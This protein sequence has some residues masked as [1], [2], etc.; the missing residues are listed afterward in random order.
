MTFLCFQVHRMMNTFLFFL[1]SVTMFEAQWVLN[2]SKWW[3]CGVQIILEWSDFSF[4]VMHCFV[5]GFYLFFGLFRLPLH[6]S[7]RVFFMCHFWQSMWFS[8]L[9]DDY[10]LMLKCRCG[11]IIIKT[12]ALCLIASF[13]I[14][15]RFIWGTCEA[16]WG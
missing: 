8:E 5:F 16:E 4:I 13:S 11:A 1:V 6:H 12:T 14:F 7:C 2:S 3:F 15:A 10:E 9:S